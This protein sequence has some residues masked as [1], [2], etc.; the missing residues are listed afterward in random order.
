[1]INSK[2]EAMSTNSSNKDLFNFNLSLL[3]G[4]IAVLMLFVPE[5]R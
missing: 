2:D 4:A 5:I 1:M 3:L